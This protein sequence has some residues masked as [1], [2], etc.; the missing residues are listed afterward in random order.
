MPPARFTEDTLELASE[1]AHAEL[2][3]GLEVH[4]SS[5]DE[6]ATSSGHRGVYLR[7]Q[8]ARRGRAETVYRELAMFVIASYGYRMRLES[9]SSDR[10][11]EMREVLRGLAGS[12]KPLPGLEEARLGRAFASAT[13]AFEHWA[14]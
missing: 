12:F 10:L 2:G 7:V 5:R 8:G 4:G 9:A 1:A 13:S 14:S 11:A 6:L 3:T